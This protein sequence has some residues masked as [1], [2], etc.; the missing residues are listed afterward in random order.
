ML[1]EKIT[2]KKCKHITY[3]DIEIQNVN[4]SHSEALQP[5]KAIFIYENKCDNCGSTSCKSEIVDMDNET[6]PAEA[7][8]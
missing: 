6:I 3:R 5:I 8:K 4:I 2:C 1:K 7:M